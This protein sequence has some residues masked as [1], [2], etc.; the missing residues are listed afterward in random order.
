MSDAKKLPPISE[1]SVTILALVVAGGVYLA[2]HLPHHTSLVPTTLSVVL[3]ALLVVTNLVLLW[4]LKD[5][6][7]ST[8]FL[9]AKWTLVA[10]ALISGALEFIF[11]K[12]GVRGNLLVLIT[13]T[14]VIFAINLPIHFGFTVGRYAER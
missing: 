12:D 2:S 7:W 4:Q 5:F 1:I 11:I 13:S 6:A 9:V 8:F 3:A 14:L 10:Y